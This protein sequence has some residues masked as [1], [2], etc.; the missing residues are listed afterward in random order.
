MQPGPGTSSSDS[1]S[2]HQPEPLEGTLAAGTE[3]FRPGPADVSEM[4]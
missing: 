1:R 4:K 3:L 2:F